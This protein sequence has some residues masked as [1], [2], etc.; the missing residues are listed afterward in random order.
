MQRY[1]ERQLG[2]GERL[3]AIVR[4]MQGLYAGEPGA[5]AFRRTLSEGSRRP[6][7]G[8]EVLAAAFANAEARDEPRRVAPRKAAPRLLLE[9]L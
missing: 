3:S 7:A 4:H 2:H 5:L 8:A 6:G 1:A 9:E